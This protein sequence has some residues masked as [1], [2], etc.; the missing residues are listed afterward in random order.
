MLAVIPNRKR[1]AFHA[2]LEI[3]AREALLT[4]WLTL[5]S[6]PAHMIWSLNVLFK[7]A[8]EGSSRTKF[9]GRSSWCVH[10]RPPVCLSMQ[11][12]QGPNQVLNA[13]Q[14]FA[15]VGKEQSFLSMQRLLCLLVLVMGRFP[16]RNECG[17]WLLF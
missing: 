11:T 5:N 16:P 12:G 1:M 2:G 3:L 10:Q 14:D 4:W 15:V 8:E 17:V 13:R 9:P 7:A 6:V